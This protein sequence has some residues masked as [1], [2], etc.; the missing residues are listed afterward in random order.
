MIIY[1]QLTFHI[2]YCLLKTYVAPSGCVRQGWGDSLI[3]K[4]LATQE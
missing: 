1:T 4:A 2:K 3:S